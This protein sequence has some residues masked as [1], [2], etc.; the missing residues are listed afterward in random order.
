MNRKSK[1]A[2]QAN[3]LVSQNT[4]VKNSTFFQQK[5]SCKIACSR[6]SLS[7]LANRKNMSGIKKCR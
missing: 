2:D 1:P 3:L 6:I 7:P 5:V 4:F